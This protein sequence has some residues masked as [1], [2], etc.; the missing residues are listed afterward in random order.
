MSSQSDASETSAT[1]KPFFCHSC[2]FEFQKAQ[3]QVK[4]SSISQIFASSLSNAKTWESKSVNNANI[5][6]FS[7][8]S[9]HNVRTVSSRNCQ[10]VATVPI[11]IRT[12]KTR[13]KHSSC[14]ASS[15][16]SRW[17]RFRWPPE[18]T[19]LRTLGLQTSF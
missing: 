11:L 13:M 8:S 4:P 16:T 12:R 2:N 9:V 10:K 15:M 1:V 18:T 3:N 19:M 6:R 14:E 17:D 7:R 5:F